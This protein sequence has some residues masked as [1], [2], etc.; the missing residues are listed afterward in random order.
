MCQKSDRTFFNSP[1]RNTRCRH[2]L[3]A[4]LERCPDLIPTFVFPN[5]ARPIPNGE[6]DVHSLKLH[7]SNTNAR[8]FQITKPN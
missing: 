6:S 4:D 7:K 1:I 8:E 2:L 5:N 3:R